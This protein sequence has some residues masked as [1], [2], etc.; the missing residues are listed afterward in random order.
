MRANPSVC[1]EV[2][3]IKG[4]QQWSTVIIFG[5]YEEIPDTPAG[6]ETWEVVR[7]LLTQRKIW[8]EPG[9]AKTIV[10]GAA[11]PL[12]PVYF[13]ILVDEITGRRAS[14]ESDGR[15]G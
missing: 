5:R 7:N 9:F 2:D 4:P 10:Q 12:I 8:W 14:I 6:R 3:E 11:R 1:V 15:A 13:R